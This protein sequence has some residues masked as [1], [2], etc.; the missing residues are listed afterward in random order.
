VLVQVPV[1]E[2]EGRTVTLVE[3][4][5]GDIQER[6]SAGPA[7]SE[8]GGD[9]G[10]QVPVSL[11]GDYGADGTDSDEHV[12]VAE[13]NLKFALTWTESETRELE[14]GASDQV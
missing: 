13:V 2:G 5:W 14:G 1:D 12:A 6:A 8:A 11:I 4:G 10:G 7:R 3:T 9:D